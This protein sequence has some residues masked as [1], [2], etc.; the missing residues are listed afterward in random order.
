MLTKNGVYGCPICDF[1]SSEDADIIY[2]GRHNVVALNPRISPHPFR[3]AI[4]PIRHVGCEGLYG[5]NSL[6][7][8]ERIEYKNARKRATDAIIKSANETGN[9]LRTR[10][11]QP[12][13]DYLERP[14]VH[15]SGDLIPQ[16]DGAAKIGGMTFPTYSDA[17]VQGVG[18]APV[19]VAS[20]PKDRLDLVMDKKVRTEMARLLRKNFEFC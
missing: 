13:V 2:E 17:D 19:I 10:E 3:T 11:G 8:N 5:M 14:S 12:L 7:M 16:Y 1:I 15:W 18:P 20:F 9:I 4:I 6:S